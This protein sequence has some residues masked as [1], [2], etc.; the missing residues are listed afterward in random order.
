M[1]KMNTRN[2]WIGLVL[3]AAFWGGYA[4]KPNRH[5]IEQGPKIVLENLIPK[6]FGDWRIDEALVPIVSPEM[7]ATLKNI[8][9]QTLTRSYVSASGQKMMLSIAYGDGIDRQL[10]IHRPEYCYPAQGF[11]ITQFYDQSI[12]T[13]FGKLSLR[14][15]VA[16]NAQR[17]EP[18]SYWITIGNVSLSSTIMRKLLRIKQGLTGKVNSGMLVRISSINADKSLAFQEQDAFINA[19]LQ[20]MS[21]TQRKQLIGT[22]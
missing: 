22:L 5:S 15:L 8:Y 14:R 13:S 1:K 10:D 21:E 20:A 4:L 2:L 9:S 12:Q 16:S 17:V 11:D 19:M 18:I 6:S 7:E 3:I